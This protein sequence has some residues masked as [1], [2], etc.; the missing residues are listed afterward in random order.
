[1]HDIRK[2]KVPFI[3]RYRHHECY[4]CGFEY[5]PGKLYAVNYLDGK[6]IYVC[7]ECYERLHTTANR[8]I[9][10]MN[11]N[12]TPFYIGGYNAAIIGA[13]N[14]FGIHYDIKHDEYVVEENPKLNYG[15]ILEKALFVT[16]SDKEDRPTYFVVPTIE[17]FT[18]LD[19]MMYTINKVIDRGCVF[20]ASKEG[21]DSSTNHGMK[22]I[23]SFRTIESMMD[24]IYKRRVE[25]SIETKRRNTNASKSASNN[26]TTPSEGKRK[27]IKPGYTPPEFYTGVANWRNG[28]MS[29]KEAAASCGMSVTTFRRRL[30]A[31]NMI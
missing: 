31:N 12:N 22:M 3:D 28:C 9:L 26:Q 13:G 8:V 27:Q 30:K 19:E 4:H 11:R 5:L 15:N 25:K 6:E 16:C 1:M 20:Y 17:T 24:R 2:D 29:I 18:D 7:K 14:N 21:I 10:Y 23:S